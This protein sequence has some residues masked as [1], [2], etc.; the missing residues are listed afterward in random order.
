MG[1]W[2]W[3]AMDKPAWWIDSPVLIYCTI[4]IVIGMFML[5][6]TTFSERGSLVVGAYKRTLAIVLF[7]LAVTG[8]LIWIG[9][10]R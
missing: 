4:F 8:I 3:R 7:S 1:Q 2:Y 9:W 6:A 5:V 10:D